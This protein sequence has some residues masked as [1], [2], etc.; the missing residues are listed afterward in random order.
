MA[1]FERLPHFEELQNSTPR[2][3][4]W[5][6]C[7][8]MANLSIGKKRLWVVGFHPLGTGTELPALISPDCP[9]S[10]MSSLFGLVITVISNQAMKLKPFRQL[11]VL[12]HPYHPYNPY[13]VVAY[14]T[15][16]YIL[17]LLFHSPLDYPL[18]L[19]SLMI[20]TIIL[21]SPMIIYDVL[22]IFMI[23]DKYCM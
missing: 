12:F 10:I 16:I 19:Q 15:Y 11:W 8:R 3:K 13:H 14:I 5:G 9:V 21:L 2:P 7:A 20:S 22:M 23:L 18:F 6:W 17:I 1:Y 4:K